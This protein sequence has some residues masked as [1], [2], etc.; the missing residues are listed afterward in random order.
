VKV[1]YQS[2]ISPRSNWVVPVRSAHSAHLLLNPSALKNGFT[3]SRTRASC[4]RSCPSNEFVLLIDRT[5]S[6]R[7]GRWIAVLRG[8]A[9][10]VGVLDVFGRRN[11]A[12]TRTASSA[13]IVLIRY[14]CRRSGNINNHKIWGNG[15]VIGFTLS[16]GMRADGMIIYP[17]GGLT[18]RKVRLSP[19]Q[20]GDAVIAGTGSCD[21]KLDDEPSIQWSRFALSS[22]APRVLCM[23]RSG[24]L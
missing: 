14:A 13:E 22:S 7:C 19:T 10:D 17:S 20:C 16:S 11:T 18:S 23:R 15:S 4:C 8:L 2:E 24:V 12:L 1:A 5:I 9:V 21:D 3:T 6:C